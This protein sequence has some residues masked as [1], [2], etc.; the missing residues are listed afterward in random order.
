MYVVPVLMGKCGISLD[1]NLL[2]GREVSLGLPWSV[3]VS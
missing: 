3:L 1:E 2:L